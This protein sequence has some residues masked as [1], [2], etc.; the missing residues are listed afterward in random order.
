MTIGN[1]NTSLPSG[2]VDDLSLLLT[3]L[4][5]ASE[6]KAAIIKRYVKEAIAHTDAGREIKADRNKPIDVPLA[7]QKAMRGHKGATAAFRD[8]RR[9]L[10]REYAEYVAAAKRDDTKQKRI[11]K[12][13]PMITAGV[14]LNDK[15]RR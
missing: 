9:G 12:I 4:S 14:G 5:S 2:Q 1:V 11:V 13:L 10:Q 6:I 15:Y 7:L 3:V 8:L